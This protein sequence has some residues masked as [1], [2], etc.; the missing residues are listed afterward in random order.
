MD[1]PTAGADGTRELFQELQFLDWWAQYISDS[2]KETL[3]HLDKN[4]FEKHISMK[5]H[6]YPQVTLIISDFF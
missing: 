4:L 1:I 3:Q 2:H 6:L 5:V